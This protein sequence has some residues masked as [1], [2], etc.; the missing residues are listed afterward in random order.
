LACEALEDRCLLAGDGLGEPDDALA[1]AFVEFEP[2]AA[3]FVVT[4][5]IGDEAYPLAGSATPGGYA[6]AQMRHAYGFDQIFFD[7]G[8]IVG[9]GSGQTV[10]IVNAYHTPTAAA[11]LAAFN[12]YFG[13]PAPPDFVQVDQSGGTNYPGSSSGWALET[14]LDVQWAHAFA[15]GASI[16]LVEANSANFSDL[17][18]A[19]DYARNQPGVSVVS[20]SW[21]T[22]GEFAS[23]TS[24]DFHF[25]TPVDHAGVTFFAAAGN[26]GGPGGYPA[27]SPNVVAVGGTSLTLNASHEIASEVAWSGSGGGISQYESQPSWQN[28]V[29]TQTTTQRAMPD[30]AFDANPSTGVP[31]YDTFNNSASTPWTKVAGTSF[32]TPSWG[33]LV[34][35]ADQGRTLAGL[36]V[37]DM[38]TLMTLLYA[39]PASNF[40]DIVSGSSGGS[41]PQAAGPGYDLVTGRGSPRAQLVVDSLVGVSTVS[42]IVFN[43]ANGNGTLDGES[44][45]SGWRVYADLNANA[46]FDPIAVDQFN[47]LDVPK[48]ITSFG[49]NTVTSDNVVSGLAGDILDVNVT[50]NINHSNDGDLVITLIAPGGGEYLL[51]S[52][53]GGS[54]DNFT[55]TTFDDSAATSISQGTAPFSGSYRP[56]EPLAGLFGANP[57][58]TWR[59]RIEDTSFFNGGSLNS[60]SLEITTGDPSTLS[61]SGG[62]YL[63]DGLPDGTYQ[64]REV[65]QAPYVQ[66]AP[67]AGYYT[68]NLT[69]GQSAA[70]RNFGNQLAQTGAPAAAVLLGA[71]DTGVSSTD[72]V[73]MLNNASPG[74]ALQFQVIGTIAGATVTIESDGTPIGTAI[75]GGST[76]IVVTDGA[77]LLADG[78][79]NITARQTVPG[80]SA[81]DASPATAITIDTTAPVSSIVAVTPQVRT[82]PVNE[83]TISFNE[84][85]SGLN[86][87]GLSLVRDGGSNLLTASQTVDTPDGLTWT[88]HNLAG[89]TAAAGFYEL[90]LA[91]SLSPAIDAAG[92]VPTD[93]STS[94][95]VN[96]GV[97]AR[98]IFYNQSAFDD[99][100][101][102]I[103]A[104]DDAAIATDKTA[105]LPGAG[106]ATSDSVTSYARGINGI[107]VDLAGD[108]GT[109][110]LD[111]FSFKMSGQ[112]Q[113]VNNEPS[114]WATAPTPISFAVRAGAGEGDSDRV[115]FVWAEG[116]IVNRWLQVTVEGDDAAGG[117]NTNTGLA[118]SDIFYFGNKIGDTF[119][120]GEEGA[121][122][123][124]ATDQLQVRNNQGDTLSVTNI[125][126]FSRDF[127]IDATDQLVARNNQGE[128]LAINI[129]DPPA[130]PAAA[131]SIEPA[132]GFEE[133]SLAATPGAEPRSEFD[134]G[135][136]LALAREHWRLRFL[137][138]ASG[139]GWAG[140][141]DDDL[142]GLLVDGR[143][144]GR[145]R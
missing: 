92:N 70:G 129:A 120:F 109:L 122:V 45:L 97:L 77:T 83:I 89:I 9:D 112:A 53:V 28:G 134:S 127:S 85:T 34:A 114:T 103:D 87:N 51:A 22:S 66:T 65:L 25:T 119:T 26:S 131:P 104:A 68:V 123:T 82:T 121:F 59:L 33:A 37:L 132:P 117:F 41:S 118:A 11:D 27:Y 23:E 62:T 5:S 61:Q 58:G 95:T 133:S 31:V 20:M 116:A 125:F 60:W 4:S 113:A 2:L 42:G 36:P 10:A 76:T 21:G 139:G 63:L 98:L 44:G 46:A 130:A 86:L 29:V 126:D 7:G 48:T 18:V 99:D 72:R 56:A 142:L 107:M 50:L 143:F 101:A 93:A 49:T 115:E 124:N 64:I 96:S 67:P 144:L 6:P 81:S 1:G 24:Y 74:A 39:M 102:G 15:P 140:H 73:T 137:A 106:L 32:A 52:H 38:P 8:T 100:N 90:F 111:D 110:S 57:N 43:D 138:D 30:V 94:F 35:I 145:R 84:P 105:Y 80:Q 55:S 40:N 17:M 135:L 71:S 47:T 69:A 136:A 108:H 54:G 141:V 16:L 78:G 88:L 14:A 128:L 12:A 91:P 3:P 79:H 19:V 13:L 75:A